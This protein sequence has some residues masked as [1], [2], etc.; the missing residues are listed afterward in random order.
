MMFGGRTP[1]ILAASSDQVE[2][3]RLLLSFRADPNLGCA[4]TKETPLYFA[5]LSGNVE[6]VQILLD[7]GAC[8]S[9]ESLTEE[10]DHSLRILGLLGKEV[11]LRW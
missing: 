10:G 9:W 11:M 7:Y 6:I 8:N 4:S 1:L 5:A 2:V 3:L